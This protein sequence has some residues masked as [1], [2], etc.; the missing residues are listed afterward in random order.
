MTA[1]P[2]ERSAFLGLAFDPIDAAAAAARVDELA[3]GDVFAY[4]VT[5]NVDHVV[6]MHQTGDPR[7]SAAYRDAAMCLCDSRILSR[8]AR[9]SGIALPLVAGSDLTR[10]LLAAGLP[11]ARV[12]VVG[13]DGEL[14]GGLQSLYPGV[15]WVFHEPPMGVRHDVEART[16]IAEFVESAGADI[17]FFAIGAPQSE[18]VC[19][20]IRA[21][22]RARGVALCIGASLEFLTGTKRRAPRWMQRASLEWLHRLLSEPARLWR[23]YLVEGPRIL[24]IWWRWHWLNRRRL[25]ASSGSIRSGGA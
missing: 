10:D 18:I 12:A 17:V 23:R 16:A 20:E 1:V 2:G 21:R 7:I 24:P 8:L 15:D 4:V 22:G 11:D 13:G 3:R 5:P 6:R 14:H 25:R 9:W 19:A